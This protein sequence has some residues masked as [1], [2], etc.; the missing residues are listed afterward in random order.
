MPTDR[1][2]EYEAAAEFQG[3][4]RI[5]ESGARNRPSMVRRHPGKVQIVSSVERKALAA[6]LDQ[7]DQ[8]ALQFMLSMAKDFG[9]FETIGYRAISADTQEELIAHLKQAKT[10]NVTDALVQAKE[11]LKTR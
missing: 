5:S 2:T 8:E 11:K 1:T 6:W 4:D 7:N 3:A 9:P 10:K